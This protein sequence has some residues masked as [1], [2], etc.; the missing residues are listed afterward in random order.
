MRAGERHFKPN[1]LKMPNETLQGVGGKKGCWLW[2]SESTPEA[3]A[4]S[5]D[6]SLKV[7]T[8]ASWPKCLIL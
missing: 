4:S 3:A 6:P 8:V 2:A 7:P 1:F 5:R